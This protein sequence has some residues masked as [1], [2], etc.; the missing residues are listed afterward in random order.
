MHTKNILF[1]QDFPGGPVVKTLSFHWRGRSSAADGETKIS[2]TMRC[3]QKINNNKK[4]YS[5]SNKTYPQGK[6]SP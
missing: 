5:L 1:F 3:D 2:H 6:I 4:K